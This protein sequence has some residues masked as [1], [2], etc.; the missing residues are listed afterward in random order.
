MP[1]SLEEHNAILERLNNP[2]LTHEER[3]TALQELRADYDGFH[4]DFDKVSETKTSLEAENKDL[5]FANSKL[6]RDSF[7]SNSE[8]HKKEE[9]IKNFSETITVSQIE[10][11][12]NN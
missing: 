8:D 5:V 7:V 4:R 2:E 12:M 3:T 10:Q 9:E 6:F 1:L 11:G